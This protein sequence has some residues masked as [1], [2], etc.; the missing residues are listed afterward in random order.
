MLQNNEYSVDV[1]KFDDEIAVAITTGAMDDVDLQGEGEGIPLAEEI[2]LALS[3]D[4]QATFVSLLALNSLTSNSVIEC[5]EG[6]IAFG[7]KVGLQHAAEQSKA[8]TA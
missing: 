7:V 6:L 1:V 4:D 8:A 2:P 5:F 3:P